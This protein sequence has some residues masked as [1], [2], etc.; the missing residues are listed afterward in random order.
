MNGDNRI[1]ELLQE[2]LRWTRF[3]G[4]L[5]AKDILEDTL[6]KGQE[7]L[8]YHLSDGKSSREIGRIL[9]VGKNTVLG[10]WKRWNTIGI[11]EPV[12]EGVRGGGTR[13]RRVFDLGD[14]GIVIPPLPTP[15]IQEEDETLRG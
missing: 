12:R 9:G 6:L 14:F 11:V 15:Q 10:L 1:V 13:Y 2:M 8:I 7:R 5:R 3:Q 4:M